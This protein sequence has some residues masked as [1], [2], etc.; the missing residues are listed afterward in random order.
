MLGTESDAVRLNT[1]ASSKTRSRN[2]Y[3]VGYRYTDSFAAQPPRPASI[4]V[5]ASFLSR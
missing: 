2:R 1:R 5:R 3:R 4:D